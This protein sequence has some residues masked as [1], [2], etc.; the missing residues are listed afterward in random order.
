MTNLAITV[1]NLSK[2]YRIGLRAEANDSFGRAIFD[3]ARSPV[4]NFRKYRSLYRFSDE[5][6]SNAYSGDDILWA[7]KDVSFQ[8]EPGEVV[9][10]IGVN[11]AGKS[12]LLKVIS[13]ITPP[14][15]GT[16]SIR[17]RV[18]S[19][20]EVGTGFHPELTGR[21]NVYLN[22]TILGMRK[23]EV[24][25]KF[26]EIVAFAGVDKFLD[27]PVKRY[28]M[29]MR[30]RLAF[31]VAAHLE[32]EILIIDEVLAVGDA[33]FQ[34]KCLNKMEDV[35]KEGRT[36]LFVSHNMAAITRL[37]Q[38]GILLSAGSVIA[39]GESHAIVS[40]YLTSGLGTASMRQWPDISE[41]PGDTSVRLRTIKVIDAEGNEAEGFD[42]RH[43]I[44]LL[45][46]YDVLE[47][48]HVLMPY[49]RLS[50]EEGVIIFSTIDQNFEWHSTPR[51]KGRYTSI[52]WIPGNL[53]SEGMIYV[54][55]AMRTNHRKYRPFQEADAIAFNVVDKM[56]EGS[57]R[58]EWVG[59]LTGAVRPKLD[60]STS[61]SPA[62]D[63]IAI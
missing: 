29:G 10:I 52:A 43:P 38:R 46:E 59:R 2:V 28:S 44:G 19:L 20:L 60:W 39:D 16:I 34:K 57:A 56:E 24:D 54:L 45:M 11:G 32:P 21:E 5:E 48:G 62:D 3:F 37:C 6:L 14:T 8:V 35:G 63:S 1:E 9:G 51:S 36:V 47:D 17:G 25:R 55:A 12:T 50:N 18:S 58:G 61:F 4:K 26:D 41:A 15:K 42:I 13:N 31:A 7:L 53:L 23:L 30:V 40:Q 33:E 27:T 22:G 49:F